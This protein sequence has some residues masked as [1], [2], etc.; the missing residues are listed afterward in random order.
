MAGQFLDDF[1][2]L[3]DVSAEADDPRPRG[4]F[5]SR[6][7]GQRIQV[8]RQGVEAHHLRAIGELGAGFSGGGAVGG[9]V[10]QRLRRRAKSLLQKLAIDAE[11]FR[12]VAQRGAFHG[13]GAV[14]AL[15][16]GGVRATVFLEFARMSAAGRASCR[17]AST[18]SRMFLSRSTARSSTL[19]RTGSRGV[20]PSRTSA[21]IPRNG[22]RPPRH[23][24]SPS[25][26]TCP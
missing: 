7:A 16:S 19:A 22:A 12:V 4:R 10:G 25:P 14:A 11:H 23:G 24:R 13:E 20:L 15:A 18:S 17:V 3:V 1:H 26:G 6:K 2:L 8:L 5:G 9:G 21:R